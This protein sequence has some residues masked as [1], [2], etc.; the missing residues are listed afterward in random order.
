MNKLAKLNILGLTQNTSQTLIPSCPSLRDASR[1]CLRG[2]LFC[3]GVRKSY[4]RKSI[5]WQLIATSAIAMSLLQALLT[6][7]AKAQTVSISKNANVNTVP[8][9]QTFDYSLKYSCISA[10]PSCQNA[11]ITDV[12]PSE[13]QYV[14]T[15]LG[16]NPAE[17]KY[18][19]K[20]RKL[21]ITFTQPIAAGDTSEITVKVK[22]PAGTTPNDT[23]AKNNAN[24][25]IS[26]GSSATSST[27]SVT[28]TAENK[29]TVE[30]P[31]LST[32]PTLDQ[33]VTYTVRF[34]NPTGSDIGGLNL[35]NAQLVDKLPSGAVFV[36][37]SDNGVYDAASNTVTWAMG[38]LK[39][40][41]G[42][43][44]YNR[45]VTVKYPSSSFTTASTVNNIVE[46]YGQSVGENSSKFIDTA[47][48][49]HGFTNP[50]PNS[51]IDKG[52]SGSGSNYAIGQT[53]NYTLSAKN[54]G[55]VPLDN[56]VITDNIPSELTVSSITTGIYNNP[57]S[58][59]IIRYKTNLKSNFTNWSASAFN[60]AINQTLNVS[61]LGL[62]TNEYITA[63]QYDYGSVPIGF[64]PSTTPRITATIISPD[65]DGKNVT[66]NQSFQNCADLSRTYA[67]TTPISKRSCTAVTIIDPRSIIEPGKSI[68][69][70]AK[71]GTPAPYLPNG[72]VRFSLEVRNTSSSG[73]ALI[74]PIVADLLPPEFDYV[75][76]SWSFDKKENANAP[77]PEFEEI[78]NY[79]NT[80]RTLLRWKFTGASSFSFPGDGNKL[81]SYIYFKAKVKP[82][83]PPTNYTNTVAITSNSSPF[84]CSDNK[85]PGT[86]LDTLDLDNDGSTNDT[87]CTANTSVTVSS[88][89]A[90]TSQKLVRGELDND[91]V[92]YPTRG[93]S[94]AGGRTDYK[95]TITNP[96]NVPIKNITVVDILPFIGD[97][98][99]A[100]PSIYRNSQWRPNL[101]NAV[102]VS[103]SRIK[104][105]YSTATNPCR[106]EVVSSGP[107]GCVDDWSLT[108]P[109]DITKVQ[110]LKFDLGTII[111]K[112]QESLSLT[113]LMR[114]PTDAKINTDAWNSFAYVGTRTD[115]DQPLVP[116]EPGAVGVD[117]KPAK[118]K[119]LLVKRITRINNQDVT[120]VMDGRSDVS[121]NAPNYVPEPYA[122]DDNDPK[123]TAGYL[124]GLI[125]AGTVKPGDE[126]EYTIYFLS[127]GNVPI[128]NV[129]LCDLI[130]ANSTFVENAF[131]AG[132]GIALEINSATTNLTNINDSDRAEYIPPN[133]IAPGACN[134]AD[135][136]NNV[137]PPT[138]LQPAANKTGAVLVNVVT[139]STT[140]PEPNKPAY[141]FI[142][143]R[144]KVK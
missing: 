25:N 143:F 69:S 102:T 45:T 139:G 72:N 104:V 30:K 140:L 74:D 15:I 109:T 40:E 136:A 19:A 59:L 34:K 56:F 67:N 31:P 90:L 93:N 3:E 95:L 21:T 65:H 43:K 115:N 133:T 26:N 53:V 9:G 107:A 106:P 84:V 137:T 50:S 32:P 13:V 85:S 14:S 129:S 117:I 20:T 33:N 24:I 52:K 78:P 22:F 130:P 2:S 18:D 37:A 111:L 86:S 121:I 120:D 83:T 134:K 105:Y 75:P 132:Y 126:L 110:A 92:G 88:Q 38:D 8:S 108:P 54:T 29:F 55:N 131:A 118:A 112:P 127:S 11:V 5:P 77:T 123:W 89:A 122:T 97:T 141:G 138:Q 64:S 124:R 27:V 47:N 12:L 71:T 36:S 76:G 35:N 42:N 81:S 98:Q 60:P 51:N 41:N 4:I 82:G 114:V 10:G 103:D 44:E 49:S 46:G 128:K 99:V 63:I 48:I 79:K 116:A 7:P 1:T 80:G 61:D 113:W 73:G 17:I 70:S 144:V 16:I 66:I 94:I 96:G 28:A 87:L 101:V 119:L 100:N 39:V 142:R 125:N 135:I 91:Y 68:D 23:I 57:P 62:A 58:N 6:T